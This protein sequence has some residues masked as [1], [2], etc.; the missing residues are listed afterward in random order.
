MEKYNV[1]FARNSLLALEQFTT[2]NEQ[3]IQQLLQSFC[4][5][6]IIVDEDC[7]K[8]ITGVK[9][10]KE[11]QFYYTATSSL[12]SELGMEKYSQLFAL[13]GISIDILPLLNESQLTQMG[14][15]SARDRARILQVI[16]QIK[17]FLP[18]CTNTSEES[19]K[20]AN[21]QQPSLNS[22]AFNSINNSN[23]NCAGCTG[24]FHIHMPNT[25]VFC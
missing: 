23:C 7:Q 14:I 16:R 13:H 19:G 4:A 25:R 3:Q 1:V 12:L 24:N 11:F 17:E 9:E 5:P 21:P 15:R 8:M 2:L 18:Y 10:M 20:M 6:S 22:R